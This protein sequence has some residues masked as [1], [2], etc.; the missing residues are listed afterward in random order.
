MINRYT[1]VFLMLGV[2][3]LSGWYAGSGAANI[4]QIFQP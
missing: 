3:L 4:A 1:A 2:V